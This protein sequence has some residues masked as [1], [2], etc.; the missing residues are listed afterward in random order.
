MMIKICISLFPMILVF[1]FC[2]LRKSNYNY[3]ISLIREDGF[4]QG[5]L[6]IVF[7]DHRPQTIP[8]ATVGTLDI[9]LNNRTI[10]RPSA[11]GIPACEE[12]AIMAASRDINPI[13]IMETVPSI[14]LRDMIISR[15]SNSMHTLE[16]RL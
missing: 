12:R 5:C 11:A 10:I 16:S 7:P 8:S 14:K 3:Y 4:F 6:N 2:L 1:Y 9:T 13:G 15:L